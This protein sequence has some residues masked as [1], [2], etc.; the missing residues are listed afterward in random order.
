VVGAPGGEPGTLRYSDHV[1]G[2]GAEFFAEACRLGLEG[3]V[4]KRRGARYR[5]TRGTDWVKTKCLSR[6]EVVIGGYTDP[7]GARSGIGA[8]LA[9]P[10]LYLLY[11]QRAEM[12][13]MAEAVWELSASLAAA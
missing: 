12:S 8:L 3:V 1:V 4:S 10:G 5:S 13:P 6:Q 2:S 11:R 9:V 7:E